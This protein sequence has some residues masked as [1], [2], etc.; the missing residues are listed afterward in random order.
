[1]AFVALPAVAARPAAPLR[2]TASAFVAP[3]AA[4]AAAPRVRAARL[5]PTMAVTVG[6]PAPAF[7]LPTDGGGSLSLSDLAGKKVVLYFCTCF[8]LFCACLA[9]LP[10]FCQVVLACMYLW[11][12]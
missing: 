11:V 8:A 4:A 12:A 3:A 6:E 7:T 10:F 5:L 9:L 2:S 1:M